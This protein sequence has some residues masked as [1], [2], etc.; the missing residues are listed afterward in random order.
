[1][2]RKKYFKNPIKNMNR[3]KEIITMKTG[4]YGLTERKLN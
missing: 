3:C 4:R 1:M 2:D